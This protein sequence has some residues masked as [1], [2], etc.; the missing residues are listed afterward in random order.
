WVRAK[1]IYDA[2]A[3]HGVTHLCGAPIVMSTLINAGQAERRPLPHRVEFI[4]AAAPPPESVLAAMADAGF[5]VTHVYGLTDT[6]GPAV[7][8]EWHE[9][10]DSLDRGRVAAKKARQGVRYHAL[11]DV[12]VMNPVTM[13]AEP[14]DGERL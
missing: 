12:G 13:E 9:A 14:A 8:N 7:V 10:W 2:I 6:Y 4:T 1:A 11:D 5:N 3:D